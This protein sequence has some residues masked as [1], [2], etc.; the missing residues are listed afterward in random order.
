MRLLKIG[1][2]ASCDIV[3]HSDKVSSLHAEITLMDS[4]DILLEDKG[5]YNGT[6]IQNQAIKSGKPVKIRRGDAVR[7]GDTELQWSQIP[8]PEDNSSYKAI[9][10]IGSHFN[11]EI[12]ISGNTV[13]RYHATI[14]VGKNG[15]VYIVDHSKNGTTVNGQKIMPNNPY[16]I[17]KSSI[18]VCGGVPVKLNQTPIEWP[19]WRITRIIAAAAVL[20]LLIGVGFGVKNLLTTTYDDG[21]LYAMYNNSVVYLEGTYHFHVT[22]VPEEKL[23]QYNLPVNFFIH[24]NSIYKL[25]TV[26]VNKMPF[27]SGT[28]F[29]VSKDGKMIT[30]LH[31]VK[32]WLYG[33]IIEEAE[34]I[35]KKHFAKVLSI[36]DF[37]T[38]GIYSALTGDA[39]Y[40]SQIKVEGV[41]DKLSFVPQGKYY[42][43]ENAVTC[44]V[45]SAGDNIEEDVA[46]IQS[47]KGELPNGARCINISDSMDVQNSSLAVGE[48]VYTIGF[49]QGQNSLLQRKTN[50]KG[51]QVIAQGGNII[52]QDSEY[53]FA[54]NAPTTGG[55]SGSPVF[56]KYGM[57]VGVHHMGLSQVVTQGYNYAVKAKYVKNLVES[58]HKV[59]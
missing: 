16:P 17:K 6:F 19:Y 12:Q 18:I 10:G 30:N 41:L 39:A 44:R 45:I 46:L 56:N 31:V 11:N 13:S 4:G 15:K 9:Y 20:L 21:E 23:Q 2:D 14:K 25:E 53:D 49:P 36:Q 54:Y 27:Y 59:K 38:K 40:I 1:R 47:E 7:F 3:L 42:S 5:S 43:N 52:Q 28:G 37:R 33:N 24:D 32:P 35:F 58:P 8:M 22:G 50:E 55:A 26:D 48:H 29:F 57:L 51:I 34:A